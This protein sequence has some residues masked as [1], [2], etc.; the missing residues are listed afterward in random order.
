MTVRD[1]V[2]NFRRVWFDGI[3]ESCF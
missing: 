3:Q 1:L 2:H